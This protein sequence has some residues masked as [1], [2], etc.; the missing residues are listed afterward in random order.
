MPRAERKL[1]SARPPR[2]SSNSGAGMPKPKNP[3]KPNG[4]K[5][6]GEKP[7]G[8]KPNGEKS[9]GGAMMTF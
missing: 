2:P 5:P 7:N 1:V 6:N 8:E 4:E 3:P 9:G